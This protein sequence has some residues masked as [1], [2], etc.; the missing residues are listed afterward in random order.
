MGSIFC[1]HGSALENWYSILRNGLRNLSNTSLMTAGA[2][3]GQG[4]YAS[5][6]F[7][8]SYGYTAR[9]NGGQTKV[10]KNMYEPIKNNFVI[11]IVE[12]IKKNGYSKDPTHNI[13]V[14]PDED[15]I[16]IRYLL[17]MKNV[18]SQAL[19]TSQIKFDEH[20]NHYLK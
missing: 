18:A 1:F 8:T 17:I 5:S 15:D 12:I 3:Y 10:W 19:N 4:I 13:V 11:G 20:Y 9:Y 7:S 2:A 6:N 16:I 14:V